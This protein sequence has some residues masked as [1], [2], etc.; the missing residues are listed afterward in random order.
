[1]L[2]WGK[3]GEISGFFLSE[4]KRREGLQCTARLCLKRKKKKKKLSFSAGCYVGEKKRGERI[5]P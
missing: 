4:L 5:L 1:L 3:K 2:P